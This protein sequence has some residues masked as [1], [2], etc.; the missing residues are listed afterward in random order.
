MNTYLLIIVIIMA[1]YILSV[2][3]KA[4]ILYK[5]MQLI[6]ITDYKS[7]LEFQSITLGIIYNIVV[8]LFIFRYFKEVHSRNNH[9]RILASQAIMDYLQ[10]Q[11][12]SKE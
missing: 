12:A 7:V 1:V 4:I 6:P 3:I 11:P 5:E 10:A 8:P 2:I 9:R